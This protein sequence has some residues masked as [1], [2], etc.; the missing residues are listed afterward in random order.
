VSFTPEQLGKRGMTKIKGR[1]R[2]DGLQESV[3]VIRDLW[4]CP[5]ITAK[6]EHDVWFSQGFCHAQDRL[7]QMERTRRFARGTLS[8][9]LGEPL[10][11]IDK[12]YRRLG[13]QRVAGRDWPQLNQ[14]AQDILQAFSDGVNAAIT[15]MRQLPPEFAVLELEPEPWTPIDSIAAWKVIYLTQTTDMD[16]DIFR[17]S[18]ARELGA[19]AA[20][21]LEPCPPENAPVVYPPGS[22][23]EGLGQ[24]I[25]GMSA[26]AAELAPNSAP[27]GGSNNWA[28]DGTLS[29]SGKPIL[30]GDPHAVI[31]T[32][33]VWYINHLRT[34]EWEITG[35]ST[36]GVP[37]MFLYGH[38]GHVGWTVTNALADIADLFVERFDD[39]GRKYLYRGKWLD[40]GIR[41]EEIKVKGRTEPVVEDIPVTAHGPLV[42]GGPPG[43]GVPLAWQWTG[44]RVVS[45]FECI[46]GMVRAKDVDEFRES[47]R[48]WAGPPMNRITADDS[49][50]I[51][52]QLL[53][54]IPVR[55]HGGA[56][57]VPVPGW[58]GEYDWTG[59]IPFEELPW[60][61][62][63]DRHFLASANNRV[64]PAGYP[65]HINALTI[66]YR[67]WRIEDLLQSRS[68]FTTEDFK[69]IQGDRYSRPA[70]SII[71]VLGKADV[72]A[73]LRPLV[74]LMQSWDCVLSPDKA[75]PVL[76]EVFMQKLLARVFSCISGLDG[77]R[78]VLDRWTGCYLP[79][80]VRQ[81]ETDDC[82][83]LELNEETR[84][85][86]WQQVMADSL[87]EAREFLTETQGP[88]MSKREWSRL[89]RQTFI[90]NL[91]R[92]PPHDEIFNIPSV[93]IGGDG[94]TIF[95]AP[96][97]YRTD[98]KINMGVSF[99]MIVD[100]ADLDSAVWVLPPGQSGHPGSP[101][102]DDNIQPWLN[103]DYHPLFWNWERIRENQEG[104]LWL[105][106][107]KR[108][109]AA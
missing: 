17:A 53:G 75:E 7:W 34:P 44:H 24:D 35:V 10:V 50:N 64:V 51:A 19:E 90:H 39:S 100:F 37:G 15:S 61:K 105:L 25:T 72:P 85:R 83:L 48:N 46:P 101:H 1:I 8:E 56:N 3:S 109:E 22:N 40:A 66:P 88:D 82:R 38:N 96:A 73:E 58:T 71:T 31:Q 41:R 9:I 97:G 60:V 108:E 76:Y 5:H 20:A 55:A 70:E 49:G 57:A 43:P 42:S 81:M 106:P 87:G 11:R 6:N 62:N 29:A 91:G 45:T 30:A 28:V 4:G 78:T 94:T 14:E 52:Y 2:A 26:L 102:Y 36:P 89:H 12:Y 80:L 63:P 32:A 59:I 33:P 13:I 84:G 104:T 21:F 69:R 98:F 93:G 99:R 16:V 47:Q 74:E 79:N 107:V 86:T 18:I 68:S 67:A 23:G 92:T 103:L 54:D 27:E 95:N 77:A 65:Y